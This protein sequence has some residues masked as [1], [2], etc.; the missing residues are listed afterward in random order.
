M[1][2]I[3]MRTFVEAR[4]VLPR[5]SS[6]CKAL[7]PEFENGAPLVMEQ[8]SLYAPGARNV[9]LP[10]E[11]PRRSTAAHRPARTFPR[12]QVSSGRGLAEAPKQPGRMTMAWKRG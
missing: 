7:L 2:T 10:S 4:P 9:N 3:D 5:P 1:V 11:L 6:D 8:R 12:S